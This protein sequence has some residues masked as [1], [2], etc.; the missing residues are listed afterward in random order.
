MTDKFLSQASLT[1]KM[2][3]RALRAVTVA[4]VATPERARPRSVVVMYRVSC[5]HVPGLHLTSG[6]LLSPELCP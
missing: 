4:N 1:T 5:D 6:R 3:E 2:Q